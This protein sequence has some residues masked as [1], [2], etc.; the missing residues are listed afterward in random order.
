MA[1]NIH[2]IKV[3]P[4]HTQEEAVK[5]AGFYNREGHEVKTR[6][7]IGGLLVVFGNRILDMDGLIHTRI[8]GYDKLYSMLSN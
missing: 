8:E 1:Q 7:V 4:F 5:A 6:Q 3:R 2:G